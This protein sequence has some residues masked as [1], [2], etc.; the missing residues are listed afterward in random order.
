MSRLVR[1]SI[2]M[3]GLAAGGAQAQDATS[4][5]ATLQ[6]NHIHGLAFD[7]QEE[8]RVL[9]A[10]HH[11]LHA[12]DLETG[13]VVPLGETRQ[14]FMG[15]LVG[16]EGRFFASGHPETGGN[17]GVLTSTD[18]GA[19]WAKLSDGVG[20]PVDFHQMTTS[21]ADPQMLYGAFAG[22]LQRSRD[23]GATWKVVGPAPDGLIDIAGSA[24]DAETLY[25][26]TETGLLRSDDGGTTWE[27]VHPAPL[28]ATF[29]ETGPNGTL[30]TFILSQG[31]MRADEV[32]LGW[33]QVSEPLGGEYIL[34]FATDGTRAVAANGSGALLVSDTGGE[35][36][37]IL[38]D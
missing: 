32:S 36:W 34:H 16:S 11:G 18:Q 10:T 12:L 17:S 29:V 23:A 21:P 26:A 5:S 28:P 38:G 1:F 20:G 6:G 37:R 9:L 25:A 35:S 15:F 27:P 3:L 13:E 24:L 19:S 22:G 4:L 30:Y 8:G 33:T 14:D 2:V 31:L 7:P